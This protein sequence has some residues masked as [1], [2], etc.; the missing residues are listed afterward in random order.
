MSFERQVFA[1]HMVQH[2]VETAHAHLFRI[3]EFQ[4]ARGS[5]ARV[6]ERLQFCFGSFGVEAVE[7]RERHVDFAP[8]LELLRDVFA[9]EDAGNG[10]DVHDVAGDV[11]A[12]GTVAACQGTEQTAVAVGQADGRAVE[13]EFAGI[14]KRRVG[15][16]ADP[17]VEFVEFFLGVGVSQREHR[18][19][20]GD[21]DEVGS[22]CGGQVAAD[23]TGGA[24][25]RGEFGVSFLKSLQFTH[26][27]VEF[28][29]RDGGLVEHVIVVVVPF[30]FPF[31]ERD[32]FLCR[33]LADLCHGI[34]LH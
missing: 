18:I 8:D 25:F 9:V 3:L 6:G 24:V 11:I 17:V 27:Q 16:L 19:A 13:L 15:G 21:L 34:I 4:A 5:I 23:V 26:Q 20:V 1:E 32:P 33:R 14:S 7:C 12:L 31:Q 30:E 2:A 28:E 10:R 22:R 29:V